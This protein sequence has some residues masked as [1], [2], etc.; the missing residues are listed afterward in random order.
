MFTISRWCLSSLMQHLDLINL[1]IPIN[2][3]AEQTQ[4]KA[5]I[6]QKWSAVLAIVTVMNRSNEPSVSWLWQMVPQSSFSK[7]SSQ[8]FSVDSPLTN[9][10][11]KQINSSVR[12]RKIISEE[13]QENDWGI[14]NLFIYLLTIYSKV[15]LDYIIIIL[16]CRRKTLYKY[17]LSGW[18]E[19][20]CMNDVH[21]CFLEYF[22]KA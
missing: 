10:I 11:R 5:N 14:L 4:A 15:Y 19:S 3:N 9:S 8:F 1:Y 21:N 13:F 17:N 18:K 16:Y 7:Q 22:K 20:V 6:A 12:M 2:K